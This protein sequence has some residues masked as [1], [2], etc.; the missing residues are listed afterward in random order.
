MFGG[1]ER[2]ASAIEWIMSELMNRPQ[3]LNMVQKELIEVVGLNHRLVEKDLENP[4]YV[5]ETLRLHPPIPLLSHESSVDDEIA[6]YFIPKESRVVINIT[7]GLLVGTPTSAMM[8][9]LSSPLMF[10]QEGV[11][12]FK[13][14][15]FEYISLYLPLYATGAFHTGIGGGA[16]ASL[17]YM[18][19]AGRNETKRVS[20]TWTI[21]SDS[22]LPRQNGCC[23]TQ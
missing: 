12:D 15:N 7:R 23:L 4:T 2:V 17:F 5:E 22:P 14:S 3:D 6:G 20:L 10:L 16:S 21:C 8:Q 13:G 1:T 19:V 11:P 18:E 9:R